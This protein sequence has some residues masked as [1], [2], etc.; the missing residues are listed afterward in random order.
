MVRPGARRSDNDLGPMTNRTG[1]VEGRAVTASSRGVGGRHNTSD[2]P[3]TSAPIGPNPTQYFSKTQIPLNEVSSPGLQLSAQFFKQ[4]ARSVPVDS[5]YSSA[6]YRATDCDNPS[7]DSG[8]GRDSC[9]SR[10]EETVRVSSLC[11]HS[12]EDDGDER[13]D[14]GGHDDD[15]DDD[16][17]NDDNDDDDDDDVDD[18][19][20]D[21]PI[22]VA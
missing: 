2:I 22:H 21:E 18:D 19:D 13:E 17:D 4:L 6:D 8:L 10:S 5:S 20:D 1:R 9:T 15:D 16:G 3:S 11:I 14:D 7:S 12:V